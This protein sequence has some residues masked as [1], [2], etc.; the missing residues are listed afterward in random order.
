MVKL[1]RLFWDIE[2]SPNVMFSW[3]CGSKIFLT[4]DHIIEESSI[5]CICWKWEGEREVHSLAWDDGDDS[6]MV[7]EFADILMRADESVAHYGDRFDIKWLRGKCLR[8]N[9]P[10]PPDL[11][12]VDTWQIASKRFYLNSSRLDYLGKL[13]FGR[14]KIRTDFDWWKRC[15]K[16]TNPDA[17]DR[18][19]GVERMV[20]YCKRDV[21]LLEQVYHKLMDFHNAKTHAGVL[22]YG[23]KKM[24]W[25]CPHCASKKTKQNRKRVTA[26]GTPQYQFQCQSCGRYYTI[27]ETDR[28]NYL[29][30]K[31]EE[32]RKG[33]G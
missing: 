22:K 24:K 20:K 21:R 14:G 26:K 1:K 17:E 18:V 3:G 19:K 16:A 2:T 32:N 10:L 13:L 7:R 33:R 8:L 4:P 12:T 23:D 5:I 15:H 6:E 31:R 27:S 29:A 28:R 25:T 9:V 11:K 30:A